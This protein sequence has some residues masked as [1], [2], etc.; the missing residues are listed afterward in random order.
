MKKIAIPIETF[1]GKI[2]S[3]MYGVMTA[4]QDPDHELFALVFDADSLT[5]TDPLARFGIHKQVTITAR[6]I[7]LAANPDHRARAI[8]Q[9]MDHFNIHTLFALT[10]PTGKDLLP[11]IAARLDA[12]LVMDCLAVDLS[13]STAE[14]PQYSGKTVATVRV[15]GTHQIFGIRP[16]AIEPV[17]TPVQTTPLLFEYV[18][19]ADNRFEVEDVREGAAGGIDLSEA[20][21]IIS[22]GRAMQNGNNFQMLYECARLMGAA[23]GASRVAVDSGWVPHAMQVGQTGT[24]VCPKLYIACGI[25][26]SIQHFAG[27]KTAGTIV[28]INTDPKAPM[29]QQCDYGIVEDLFKIIPILTRQLKAASGSLDR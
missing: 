2:K 27:M 6:D 7:H 29:M 1:H 5:D 24:T 3:S 10:S 23:V 16:N 19:S 20:E 14:K 26:G 22:G 13:A 12:P 8:I 4:A 25:S 9:A 15:T 21:I 11:R 17:P 28:C 18:G